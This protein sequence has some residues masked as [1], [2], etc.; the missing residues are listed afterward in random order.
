[1]SRIESAFIKLYELS[2]LKLSQGVAK[3]NKLLNFHTNPSENMSIAGVRS[4]VF[5]SS[6]WMIRDGVAGV[7]EPAEL[8]FVEEPEYVF[9]EL[10]VL[11]NLS[12]AT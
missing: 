5:I 11:I 10:I 6:A 3:S 1:M 4:P 9:E 2:E 8:T 7:M 12:G